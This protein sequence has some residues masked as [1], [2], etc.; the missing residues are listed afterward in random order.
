MFHP[1][2]VPLQKN[3]SKKYEVYTDLYQELISLEGHN[4]VSVYGNKD[5]FILNSIQTHHLLFYSNE[6]YIVLNKL[7]LKKLDNNLNSV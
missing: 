7:N 2:N 3:S 4:L 6:I 5:H 1:S